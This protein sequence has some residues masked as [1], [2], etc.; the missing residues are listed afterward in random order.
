MRTPALAGVVLVCVPVQNLPAGDKEDAVTVDRWERKYLLEFI[1]PKPN[2][3]EETPKALQNLLIR[4]WVEML[5]LDDQGFRIY[6]TTLLGRQIL[7][8]K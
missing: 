6:H 1:D 7:E 8:E 5:E 2:K 3:R 4:G